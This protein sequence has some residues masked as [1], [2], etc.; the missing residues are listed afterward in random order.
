MRRLLSAF[1]LMPFSPEYRNTYEIAIK[2]ACRKCNIVCHRL[3]D[4]LDME[5]QDMVDQIYFEI[6]QSDIIIADM[7]GMNPNVFYEAGYTDG[8]NKEVI[9]ITDNINDMPF[10]LNHRRFIGYDK[11]DL[12]SLIPRLTAALKRYIKRSAFYPGQDG[13]NLRVRD[14]EI[15]FSLTGWNKWGGID[16]F[17]DDNAIMLRGNIKTAGYVN[18]N[19][20][21]ELAGKT[22]VIYI[23]N[24]KKSNYSMNRLLKMTVNQD[25]LLK[26]KNISNLLISNEYIPAADGRVEYE[27]PADFNGKIG[28]V[29]YETDFNNLEI[30]AFY[31]KDE[32]K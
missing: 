8:I 30:R 11:N 21:Q 3:D 25:E 1:V 19:I 10:N 26:P 32:E 15:P 22:L 28:F 24:T 4:L 27:I 7:S 5:N 23:S 20:N 17:S 6:H 13:R 16:V 9:L 12:A 18:E 29:F 31:K 2:P 14:G